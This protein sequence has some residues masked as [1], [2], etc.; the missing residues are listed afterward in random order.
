MICA[1]LGVVAHV[2]KTIDE[3]HEL[4]DV[5]EVDVHG[6]ELLVQLILEFTH[7][8]TL[9]ANLAVTSLCTITIQRLTMNQGDGCLECRAEQD[10]GTRHAVEQ[11][12]KILL[13][14]LRNEHLA[15]SKPVQ[16]I[17]G[18]IKNIV[19]KLGVVQEQRLLD[20]HEEA[21][22]Q[23][24]T[25][26]ALD[27]VGVVLNGIDGASQ[28]FE[29]TAD[30]AGNVAFERLVDGGDALGDFV[31][32]FNQTIHGTTLGEKTEKGDSESHIINLFEKG[33]F[34]LVT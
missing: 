1:I 22:G 26:V 7:I 16:G 31:V 32:M 20:S 5:L 21:L 4:I 2:I 24:V 27:D 8:V 13:D 30:T 33:S 29:L 11:V 14:R 15:H 9:S 19:L 3:V 18:R 17:L 10:G 34:I 23:M 12:N 28:L 6:V 25:N